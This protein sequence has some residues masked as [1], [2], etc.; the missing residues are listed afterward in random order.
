MALMQSTMLPLQTQAPDFSLPDVVS[1]KIISLKD[2]EEKDAFL[3]F[4]ICKHC[5][6][7]QHVKKELAKIGNEYHA[8][9]VGVIAISAND[10][11]SYPED[12][13]ESLKEM[14][15]ELHFSFPFLYDESQ[16]TAK[17]YTAI[18]T[19]DIFLFDKQKKLVYRGQIDGSR[20]GNNIPITGSD[21]RKALDAVLSGKEVDENQ[22]P[23]SGCSIK[24]KEG[25]EPQYVLPH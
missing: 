19:P 22:K 18:C 17:A 3:I 24:W 14:A 12:Q 9:G 25:N 13:P 21:L 2:F 20:P 6:Y 1:D 5:P 23:S 7:V 11:M 4:F 10:A 8:K 16:E 15:E